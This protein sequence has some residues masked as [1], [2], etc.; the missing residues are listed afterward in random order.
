MRLLPLVAALVAI[1]APV[2]AACSAGAYAQVAPMCREFADYAAHIERNH[3][4]ADVQELIGGARERF[5]ELARIRDATLRVVA[6]TRP[7]IDTARVAVLT[8]D[9]VCVLGLLTVPRKIF[10]EI[11][12]NGA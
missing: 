1:A 10:D 3:P 12:G 11:A 5:G 9:G 8:S 6:F 7:G 2:W 4:D